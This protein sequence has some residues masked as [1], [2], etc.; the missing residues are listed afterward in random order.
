MP[1]SKFKETLF[2]T[3]GLGFIG[4]NYLNIFVPKNLGVRYVNID[5]LTKVGSVSNIK[6]SSCLNY[7]WEKVDVRNYKKLQKLF[8]KYRP[9]GLIH[10]AAETHVDVSIQNPQL[11]IDTNVTG[12]HNLLVLS[13]KYGLRRFLQ[14]STDEVYGALESGPGRFSERS[15]LAPNNPYSASKAAAEML[16]R[17]Y[18][19]TYRLPVVITRASN[20]YGPNQDKTKLLPLFITNLLKGIKVP[21]YGKGLQRREWL[22]VDDHARAIDLVYRHG[23]SGEVYNIGGSTELTN[24]A[25]T[26]KLLSLT[27]RNTSFIKYVP[28]RLGHDF[29]Y[30]LNCSKIKRELGWKPRILFKNGLKT[31][32]EFYLRGADAGRA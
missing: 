27:D 8:V 5:C 22:Y 1:K 20:T 14:V 9:S 7:A 12:T 28:D 25:L 15:P 21:L 2:V 17:S 10:F 30:A 32:H 24:L 4:S 26:K 19:K 6:V 3:G 31:T 18:Y 13:L 23:K 16:A 29:R 11:F